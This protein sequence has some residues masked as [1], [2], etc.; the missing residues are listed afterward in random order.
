MKKSSKVILGTGA[1]LLAL[2]VAVAETACTIGIKRPK[3][4]QEF[5]D[6][7]LKERAEWRKVNN[8]KFF[9]M[10][11][12]DVSLVSVNGEEMKGWFLPAENKTNRFVLCIHGYRCNGVD[13]FSH[14]APFYHNDLGYNVLM[15]DLT[16]HGRS[17]GK[18]AGFGTFDSENIFLWVNWIIENFG[19]DVEIILHGISMGAATALICNEKNPPKQ[20]K[21][22]ISDCAFISAPY[23]MNNTV[24]DV[25]GFQLKP[26]VALG[27]VASK[28][29]AGYFFSESNPLKNMDKAKN[30]VLFIHGKADTFVPFECG[31]M[32]YDACPTEKDFYWVDDAIHAFSYYVD[33]DG[34]ENKVKQ[35][36]SAHLDTKETTIA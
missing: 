18:Y 36:I 23:V 12:Q 29:K 10:N 30:P 35:F 33:K 15:P 24:K 21:L 26:F 8:E 7:I 27:S 22:I 14:I 11:P 19:E 32:L 16:A 3:K 13:E 6:G 1:G 28:I 31:Q 25:V 17:E 4:P 20:V 34:Y 9:A 5:K 2:S